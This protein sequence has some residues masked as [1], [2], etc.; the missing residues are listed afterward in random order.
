MK[1]LAPFID[2]I[3]SLKRKDVCYII[4]VF[5]LILTIVPIFIAS[6]YAVLSADDFS[7]M[8]SIREAEGGILLVKII[9]TVRRL[10]LWRHYH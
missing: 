7:A 6:G 4:A 5:F 2:R 1:N 9:N 10:Y 3:K 8:K